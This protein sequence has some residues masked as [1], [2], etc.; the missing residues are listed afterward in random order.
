MV[1]SPEDS[2]PHRGDVLGCP[3]IWCQGLGGDARSL[4][5]AVAYID[6]C[7][8][9]AKDWKALFGP[10]SDLFGLKDDEKPSTDG[11]AQCDSLNPV[12]APDPRTQIS[13]ESVRSCLHAL[14]F[15][16]DFATNHRCPIRGPRILDAIQR[17]AP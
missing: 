3:A 10:F 6:A 2:R 9:K 7:R 4:E 15:E 14:R 17:L 5:A 12:R 1:V 11:P 8:L 13:A 16:P